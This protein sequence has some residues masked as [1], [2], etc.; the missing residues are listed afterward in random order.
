MINNTLKS[1]GYPENYPHNKEC[2][3]SIPLPPG[4]MAIN[5]S[6]QEVSL[7]HSVS[8]KYELTRFT[9]LH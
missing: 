7:E 2:V 4:M 5:I 6:L 9:L 8:C 1:P 3:S